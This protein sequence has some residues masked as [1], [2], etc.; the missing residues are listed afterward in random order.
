MSTQSGCSC[1]PAEP[2]EVAGKP[3]LQRVVRKEGAHWQQPSGEFVRAV[4]RPEDAE[5]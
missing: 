3:D 5:L 4:M 2:R 1:E